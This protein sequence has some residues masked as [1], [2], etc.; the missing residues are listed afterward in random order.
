MTT[1]TSTTAVT[2]EHLAALPP[3]ELLERLL[4]AGASPPP[5][6]ARGELVAAA[7]AHRLARGEPLQAAGV[8]EVLPEGFGFLR[9]AA[10]DFEPSPHDPFVSPSQVRGLNLKPG[11]RLLGALRA[12]KGNERF[13]SLVQ[14]E[15]VHDLPPEALPHCL[16]FSART[17]VVGT[18]PLYLAPQSP[19]LR[20]LA[21]LAPWCRGQRM[22][23][24]G[25]PALPRLAFL[26]DVALGLHAADPTLRVQLG[27]LDQRPEDLAAARARLPSGSQV[28]LAGTTF[29]Q[30]AARPVALAELLLAQ[31][32][33]DVEQGHDVVLLVDSL[34]AL[35]R[36]GQRTEAPSGRWL[37]PGLDVQATAAGKRLFAAARACAEGGSLT[38]LATAV[39]DPDSA[40]DRA[41]LAEF[42]HCGNSEVVFDAD[43]DTEPTA[44]AIQFDPRATRTRPEDD[45]RPAVERARAAAYRQALASV[46]PAA[47]ADVP[48]L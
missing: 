1:P 36:A 40:L 39:A 48:L 44:D 41:V 47:R 35:A 34:T 2:T 30:G 37:C 42:R 4:A 5:N 43:L 25:P 24:V 16:A 12:P 23:A 8:L 6:L 11:H 32:Q 7:M 21:V 9:S 20:A 38:V 27:A 33:R 18:K 10:L 19:A 14:V 28:T 45:V 29:D 15:R 17:P 26:V 13:F 3:R 22:L 31:A 46:A